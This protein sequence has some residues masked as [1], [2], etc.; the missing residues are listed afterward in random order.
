MLY[1]KS[2]H[3]SNHGWKAKRMGLMTLSEFQKAYE[4]LNWLDVG[5]PSQTNLRW[6]SWRSNSR[7]S[8]ISRLRFASFGFLTFAGLGLPSSP[9]PP[10]AYHAYFLETT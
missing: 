7:L 6:F 10:S 1:Q 2:S 5:P 3:G 8:F 4:S 9:V